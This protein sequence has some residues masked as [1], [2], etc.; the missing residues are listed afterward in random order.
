MT[1]K[2]YRVDLTEEQIGHIMGAMKITIWDMESKLLFPDL[3]D[4]QKANLILVRETSQSIL[5]TLENLAAK[6]LITASVGKS[7]QV[8]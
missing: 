8:H 2:Q 1:A 6:I 5:T 7:T 3:D 4:A